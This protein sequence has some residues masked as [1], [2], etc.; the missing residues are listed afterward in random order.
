M[1][2]SARLAT[3]GVRIH[4]H[5]HQV[6]AETHARAFGIDLVVT[7]NGTA[8][9][10]MAGR[11]GSP[12]TAARNARRCRL[13]ARMTV[14]PGHGLRVDAPESRGARAQLPDHGARGLDG[15]EPH[16]EGHPAAVGDVVEADGAGVGDQ[17]VDALVG[18]PELLGRHL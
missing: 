17:R 4:L 18:D 2:C 3:S 7:G 8:G 12:G 16:G 15:G 13:R 9:L 5:I 1:R 10:A 14:L 6:H 11:Q